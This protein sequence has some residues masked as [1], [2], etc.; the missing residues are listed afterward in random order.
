MIDSVIRGI[1]T[2]A[3]KCTSSCKKA[4]K[5]QE[6]SNEPEVK[7]EEN[8]NK[9]SN[10]LSN[11]INS[12]LQVVTAGTSLICG[13]I[14]THVLKLTDIFTP[15]TNFVNSS[16]STSSGKS[17]K[18]TVKDLANALKSVESQINED[19]EL[20][21]KL[22]KESREKLQVLFSRMQ[23]LSKREDLQ[24]MD[25]SQL[26]A[27]WRQTR[28]TRALLRLSQRLRNGQC[29]PFR[30]ERLR[31][32]F[33][34]SLETLAKALEEI[35]SHPPSENRDRAAQ[36][37]VQAVDHTVS[38]VERHDERGG[39]ENFTDEDKRSVGHHLKEASKHVENV[40]QDP[41][42]SYYVS[43][44]Y[45]SLCGLLTNIKGFLSCWLQEG[46]E[47]CKEV[48]KRQEELCEERKKT[49]I[50]FDKACRK[51]LTEKRRAEN[52][53][54]MMIDAKNRL[55]HF[56]G[57]RDDEKTKVSRNERKY[58]YAKNQIDKLCA[59]HKHSELKYISHG[60]NEDHYST[61]EEEISSTI[62]PSYV[63][64]QTSLNL[65][66]DLLC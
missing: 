9:S 64:S 22:S 56:L 25:V 35:S 17:E 65:D 11:V 37:I 21:E 30:E 5:F 53:R 38:A 50:N 2:I 54:L 10:I 26:I 59:E 20:N 45:S 41:A 40:V 8:I 58:Q 31:E 19:K 18:K 36:G 6:K 15:F 27:Q 33:V 23:E 57:I 14:N 43:S 63:C 13:G 49:K 29:V 32:N 66:I 47:N 48:K 34:E 16:G 3:S 24:N 28:S 4:D 55:S 46:E 61:Q 52:F 51:H 39:D 7:N 60:S 44:C 42:L 62:G 1:T 12:P